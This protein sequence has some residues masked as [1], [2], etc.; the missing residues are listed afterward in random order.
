MKELIK[1]LN[2]ILKNK[3]EEKQE[4]ESS[5]QMANIDYAILGQE[6]EKAKIALTAVEKGNEKDLRLVYRQT[7]SRSVFEAIESYC[8]Q[9]QLS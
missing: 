6:I 4:M 9:S 2:G 1:D 5:D 3:L 7:T 8:G